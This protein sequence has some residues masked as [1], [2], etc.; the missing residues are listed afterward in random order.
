MKFSFCWLLNFVD[1]LCCYHH[2]YQTQKVI[3][4]SAVVFSSIMSKKTSLLGAWK[5]PQK[6]I[7]NYPN[8]WHIRVACL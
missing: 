8:F 4:F 2:E 6:I 7:L 3:F 1:K 5:R